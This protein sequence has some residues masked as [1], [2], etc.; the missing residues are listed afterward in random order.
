MDGRLHKN[1]EI[2]I[3]DNRYQL[4]IRGLNTMDKSILG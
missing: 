4:W 3:F 2:E 1:G